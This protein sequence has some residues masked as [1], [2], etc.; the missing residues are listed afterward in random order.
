MVKHSSSHQQADAQVARAELIRILAEGKSLVTRAFE[1]NPSPT[2]KQITIHLSNL[3]NEAQKNK[4]M[5]VAVM[6]LAKSGKST[7]LNALLGGE[8]LPVANT[9]ETARVVHI[10]HSPAYPDGRL[11]H[12]TALCAE[13]V[14]AINTTLKSMNRSFRTSRDDSELGRLRLE[15]PIAALTGQLAGTDSANEIKFEL[16]DTP[17]PNEAGLEGLKEKVHSLINEADALVYLL[18]YTKLKT[19]SEEDLFK[20]LGD[21]RP[22]LRKRVSS[23]LFFVVNK[24]EPVSRSGMNENETRNYVH[25]ILN[26]QLKVENLDPGRIHLVSAERGFLA[27]MAMLGRMNESQR[28]DIARIMF[29]EIG[30][31]KS[32]SKVEALAPEFMEAS[33]LEVFE[34]SVLTH[35]FN[36]RINL[37]LEAQLGKGANHLK[38]LNQELVITLTVLNSDKEELSRKCEQ[39]EG[40]LGNLLAQRQIFNDVKQELTLSLGQRMEQEFDQFFDGMRKSIIK[41]INADENASLFHAKSDQSEPDPRLQALNKKVARLLKEQVNGFTQHYLPT[42]GY[43]EWYP[44]IQ[45]RLAPIIERISRQIEDAV[46]M[47]LQISLAPIKLSFESVDLESLLAQVQEEIRRLRKESFTECTEQRTKKKKVEGLCCDSEEDYIEN[48]NIQI[49]N[50]QVNREEYLSYWVMLISEIAGTSK[51]VASDRL[52]KAIKRSIH[53]AESTLKEYSDSYTQNLGRTLSTLSKDLTALTEAR[54]NAQ[55]HL[56]S[57]GL[58]LKEFADLQEYMEVRP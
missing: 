20:V 33:H 5:R 18:D 49:R 40:E 42:L 31:R 27:R 15:V 23:T 35:V 58:L 47:R 56:E 36:N 12:G 8:F 26:C 45:E 52:G 39:L 46:G 25:N 34:R 28:E 30:F 9:P 13:G 17:G 50:Y 37:L 10:A 41:M 19:D 4:T 24:F 21:L 14:E 43:D 2:L 48:I 53:Q 29:G 16:I 6:A 57:C 7:L 51:K 55:E 38:R 3:V 22:E 54:S 32:L 1:E 11:I 44:A